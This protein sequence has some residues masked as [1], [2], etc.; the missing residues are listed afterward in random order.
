[1]LENRWEV[2]R[3][4]RYWGRVRVFCDERLVYACEPRD[5]LRSAR[6]TTCTK[7]EAAVTGLETERFAYLLFHGSR[8]V[9]YSFKSLNVGRG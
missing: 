9:G 3:R 7:E 4:T 6:L 2:R 1:M 8:Q 5:G